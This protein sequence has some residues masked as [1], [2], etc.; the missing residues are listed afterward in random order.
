MRAL[1]PCQ[2]TWRLRRRLRCGSIESRPVASTALVSWMSGASVDRRVLDFPQSHK[3]V[4]GKLKWVFNETWRKQKPDWR[5]TEKGKAVGM[6][7]RQK[8]EAEKERERG[9]KRER[10]KKRKTNEKKE[11]KREWKRKKEK[12]ENREGRRRWEMVRGEMGRGGE[13]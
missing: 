1:C 5:K 13:R 6:E 10:W 8:R 2:W 9:N 11:G 7:R 3:Y 4:K 12:D